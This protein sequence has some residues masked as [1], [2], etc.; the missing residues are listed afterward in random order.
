MGF[1]FYPFGGHFI[2]AKPKSEKKLSLFQFFI[3]KFFS[4]QVL[5]R[6][7]DRAWVLHRKS[8]VG[9]GA[10]VTQLCCWQKGV[11][12]SFALAERQDKDNL[13]CRGEGREGRTAWPRHL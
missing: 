5:G 1:T 11:G 6:L 3:W 13:N 12:H 8:R 2:I 7:K 10:L 4:V 9:Q